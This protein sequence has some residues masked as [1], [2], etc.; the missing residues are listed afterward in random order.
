M[1]ATLSLLALLAF[2]CGSKSHAQREPPLAPGAQPVG[3]QQPAQQYH[4][5]DGGVRGEVLESIVVPPKGECSVF[6]AAANRMGQ[7]FAGWRNDHY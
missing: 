2:L 4:A 3:P 6:L 1:R 5:E 7:N